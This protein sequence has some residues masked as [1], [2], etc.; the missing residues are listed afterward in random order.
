MTDF[1][2]HKILSIAEQSTLAKVVDILFPAEP[3]GIGAVS[4]GA[5]RYIEGVLAERAAYLA[6]TYKSGVCWLHSRAQAYGADRFDELDRAVQEQ[7]VDEVM[8]RRQAEVIPLDLPPPIPVDGAVGE[9]GPLD[10]LFMT[11]LWQHTREAL[12]GDPRHGGNRDGVIWKWLGYSGPQLNGYTDLEI[13]ENQTPQRPLR[14]A[15]D[16]RNHRG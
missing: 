10:L 6:E 3:D 14:F 12:F 5:L 4:A 15:D 8:S 9:R 11:V 1:A 2:D 13:L 16:W 7:I